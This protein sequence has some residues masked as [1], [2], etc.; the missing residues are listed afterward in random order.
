MQTVPVPVPVA[1]VEMAGGFSGLFEKVMSRGDARGLEREV[2]DGLKEM[3]GL[4]MSACVRQKAR[5]AVENNVEE[6]VCSH[7]GD[8]A[9]LLDRERKRHVVA[10][11]G[12]VDYRRSVYQCTRRECRGERAPLENPGR[13]SCGP[14]E[15]RHAPGFLAACGT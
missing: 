15:F 13:T 10:I 5:E 1:L 4:F 14:T 11:R 7:C 9:R 8:R 2:H 3:D 6:V 12:H